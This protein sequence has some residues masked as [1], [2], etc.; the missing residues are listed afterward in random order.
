MVYV[1]GTVEMNV[2]TGITCKHD[3]FLIP[4]NVVEHST[5]ADHDERGERRAMSEWA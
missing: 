1:S 4:N 5:V 2:L 3:K